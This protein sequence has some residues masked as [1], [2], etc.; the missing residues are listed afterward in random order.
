MKNKDVVYMIFG[1][2]IAYGLYDKEYSGWVNRI[3]I[4]LENNLNNNFIFNLGIPGQNSSDILKK[5]EEELQNRYNN[6]DIFNLIFSFGIKDALIL[7]ENEEHINVFEKNVL[8]IIQKSKKYT[9][10]IY[11]IGLIETDKQIRKEYK[12]EN[13]IRIDECLERICKEN[14]VKYIKIR[15]FIEKEDLSDGLHPNTIG[16]KKI[17]EIILN[18]IFK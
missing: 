4:S 7:N 3:R 9:E 15:N 18:E 6:E 16:H 11:F 14:N 8:E 1:D 2:S 13:I 5:F 17:S 12:I 10:N